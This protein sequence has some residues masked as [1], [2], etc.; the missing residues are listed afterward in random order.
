MDSKSKPKE[1]ALCGNPLKRSVSLV[2]EKIG[3]TNYRF[4]TN[5]C[6]TIFKRFL[7]IYGDDFG[8]PLGQTKSI[9]STEREFKAI[10]KREGLLTAKKHQNL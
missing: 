6:A 1:C 9:F 2:E 5:D 4:D 8:Q 10:K 3:S 7:A